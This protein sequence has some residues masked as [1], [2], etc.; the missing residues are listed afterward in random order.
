MATVARIATPR[1]LIPITSY[2][3]EG[4]DSPFFTHWNQ[5]FVK[6]VR[7]GLGHPAMSTTTALDVLRHY[8]PAR[9]RTSAHYWPAH[10]HLGPRRHSPE[11]LDAAEPGLRRSLRCRSPDIPEPPRLGRGETHGEGRRQEQPA[12]T[13]PHVPDHV[14][15]T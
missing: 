11:A 10:R 6:D 15:R 9:R 4:R 14:N 7:P 12:G 5:S 3:Q 8:L 1:D 2:T 13:G